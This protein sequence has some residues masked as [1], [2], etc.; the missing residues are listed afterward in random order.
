M[1]FEQSAFLLIHVGT[2]RVGTV[3]SVQAMSRRVHFWHDGIELF[4][5]HRHASL[6]LMITR[7]RQTIFLPTC[8]T[9]INQ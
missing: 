2:P 1:Q 9:I 8:T 7:E 3:I 4:G 6:F 5:A